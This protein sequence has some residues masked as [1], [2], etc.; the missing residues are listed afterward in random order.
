MALLGKKSRNNALKMTLA[1]ERLESA[2]QWF[3]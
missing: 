3:H 2:N 1:L